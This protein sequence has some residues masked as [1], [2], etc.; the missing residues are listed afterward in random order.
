MQALT[1]TNEPLDEVLNALRRK[2][3]LNVDTDPRSPER[4]Q[5]RFVQA[6]LRGVA[7]DTLSRRDRKSRHIAVAQHLATYPDV[8]AISGV[9]AA[10]YLDA[11][12][13]VPE[14][15]DVLELRARA[16]AQ[17]E[18]AAVHAKDVGAPVDALAHYA[19]LMSLEPPDEIMVRATV[20]ASEL[21]RR[22][23]VR[24]LE[25]IEWCNR[26]VET[27][28]RLGHEE[29]VLEAR[30]ARASLMYATGRRLDEARADAEHVLEASAGVPAR[31]RLVAQAARQLT[32]SAQQG[33]DVEVAQRAATR[34]LPDVERYGDDHD[35]AVLLDT[36]A[37]WFGLAGYRRLTGLVRRAATA[38]FHERNQATISLHANLAANLV[39]DDPAE[40]LTAATTAMESARAL[41]L[42]DVMG[43]GHFVAA[44]INLG[45]WAEAQAQLSARPPS[46]RASCSTGRPTSSPGRQCW[47]GSRTTRTA[48]CP[49]ASR[50]ATPR[51]W[52]SPPGG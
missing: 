47:R 14:D 38:Q 11:A 29:D 34:A 13:A 32:V 39:P 20:S 52:S 48:C 49:N 41:G 42:S 45:E 40:G 35:F 25:V 6:L 31:V 10:H 5:Y 22:T 1:T 43:C 36:M 44:A 26:A 8:D 27:S 23:G 18:R 15:D 16:A 17:L 24:M 37:M 50:A 21:A 3:I 33:G 46:S 30:M 51:T 12:A 7:Y 9:V 4:G 28:E 19:Q 2:E